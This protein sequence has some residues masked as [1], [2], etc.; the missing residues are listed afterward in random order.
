MPDTNLDMCKNITENPQTLLPLSHQ[1][2][3]QDLKY[4]QHLLC[5][6]SVRDYLT[7]KDKQITY[8]VSFSLRVVST[9][10]FIVLL[11]FYY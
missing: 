10:I 3:L 4:L 5:D 2:P 1:R 9:Y 8:N 7:K 11:K 6:V